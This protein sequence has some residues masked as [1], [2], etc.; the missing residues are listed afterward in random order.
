MKMMR[1]HTKC[2]CGNEIVGRDEI[3]VETLLMAGVCREC[4]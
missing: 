4:L 2:E 3:E 1:T